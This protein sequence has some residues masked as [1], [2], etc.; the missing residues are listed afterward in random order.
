MWATIMRSHWESRYPA[1]THCVTV[2]RRIGRSIEPRNSFRIVTLKG[3]LWGWPRPGFHGTVK[4]Q[5]F[6]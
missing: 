1:P 6:S 4:Q 5:S 2:G 3:F